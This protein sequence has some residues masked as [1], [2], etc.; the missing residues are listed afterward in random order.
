M[1][2]TEFDKPLDHDLDEL[3]SNLANK[4]NTITVN[5]VTSIAANLTVLRG[6]WF[7]IGNIIFVNVICKPTAG[8][9]NADSALFYVAPAYQGNAPLIISD[10]E[11]NNPIQAKCR[12]SSGYVRAGGTLTINHEYLIFGS[13][14][15]T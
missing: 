6:G 7:Q 14:Y 4:Q 13:F 12:V 5:S 15:T 3:N 2:A 8:T 10:S 9:W 1:G 11:G